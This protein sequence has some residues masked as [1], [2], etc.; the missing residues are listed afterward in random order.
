MGA[1][2]EC[3][4][5][6]SHLPSSEYEEITIDPTCSWK[7]V[8]I[9]PDIHIKEEQDGPVLKRCRTMS[10]THM[11]MPSVMEMI[12]ALGPGPS[13]FGSLQSSSA[14]GG[15]NDYTSQS[16]SASESWGRWGGGKAQILRDS[17]ST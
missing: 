8:P 17:N 11:V 10:P 2:V 7:P 13:P 16:E 6:T 9:K 5:Q 3:H 14:G 15:T 4:V 1:G 12:A